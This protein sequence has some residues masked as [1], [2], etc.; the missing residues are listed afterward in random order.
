M[1]RKIFVKIG[2]PLVLSLVTMA[3]LSFAQ[4]Q[5]STSG[6]PPHQVIIL[7]EGAEVFKDPNFDSEVIAQVPEGKK[8]FS[9]SKKF[10][11]TFYRIL[12][13][14]D[15]TG[16]IADSD[17]KPLNQQGLASGSGPGKNKAGKNIDS[18]TKREGKSAQGSDRRKAFSGSN[19][20]GISYSMVDYKENT[21]GDHRRDQLAF[22]GFKV[23]GPDLLVEGPMPT[24]LNILFYPGA[25]GYYEKVTGRAASGWVLLMDGIWQSYFPVSREAFG[26]YGFGPLFKFS[27]YNLGLV[28]KTTGSTSYYSAEDMSLGLVFSVGAALRLGSVALRGEYSYYWEKEAYGAFSLSLQKDF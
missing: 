27:K 7:R 20:V 4:Q 19:F 1:I 6:T 21:M 26:I 11:G 25:P 5:K 2:T 22:I 18:L 3:P 23:S 9:S 10:N 24:E 13:G 28:D 14:K 8:F 12:I 15:L 16:Y 17:A